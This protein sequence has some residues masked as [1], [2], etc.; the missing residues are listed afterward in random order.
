MRPLFQVD[1]PTRYLARRGLWLHTSPRSMSLVVRL[2]PVLPSPFIHGWT[3]VKEPV[4]GL[5][6]AAS[7]PFMVEPFRVLDPFKDA[8]APEAQL[9]WSERVKQAEQD[10]AACATAS[11][12]VPLVPSVSR[13]VAFQP[14]TDSTDHWPILQ[15]LDVITAG[16]GI[17][18]GQATS[19]GV[20]SCPWC[21]CSWIRGVILA[22]TSGRGPYRAFSGHSTPEVFAKLMQLFDFH[23]EVQQ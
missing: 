6:W 17:R 13:L 22:T 16:C 2:H 15:D 10:A 23:S 11:A 4:A 5:Y 19:V 8:V 7:P 18:S 1:R 3:M 14:R 12:A 21:S 9:S 20:G